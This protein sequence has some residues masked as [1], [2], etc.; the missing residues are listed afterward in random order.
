MNDLINA[1]ISGSVTIT[2]ASE[3]EI[4]TV[5]IDLSSVTWHNLTFTAVDYNCGAW[6]D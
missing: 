1:Q 2:P 5:I 3:R 4:V 6:D